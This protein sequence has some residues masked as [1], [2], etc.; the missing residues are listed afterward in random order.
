MAKYS[1]QGVCPICWQHFCGAGRTEVEAE[2]NLCFRLDD[3]RRKMHPGGKLS[4][5]VKPSAKATRQSA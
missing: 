1:V 3:H 4:V 2:T 5:P